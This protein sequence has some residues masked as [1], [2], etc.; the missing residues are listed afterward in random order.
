MRRLA[1]LLRAVNVG[2][3][4]LAMADLR[5][6]L[7]DGG[8]AEPQTLLASGNAVVGTDLAPAAAEA[9]LEALLARHGLPTPVLVRDLAQLRAVRSANPWPDMAR[10]DPSHLTVCFLRGEPRAGVD[11]LERFCL[12][13]ERV[14]L[15]PGCLYAAY[16]AGIGTS[17]LLLT[18][19][20]KTL[21]VTGTGRNWNT[22]GKLEAALAQ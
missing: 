12:A 2:G 11:A 20:E 5:R 19:V 8:F 14:A 17:R 13:G 16:P 3:R 4:K 22:L 6:L 15:G 18:A 1:V 21:G 7:A 9:A 10:D